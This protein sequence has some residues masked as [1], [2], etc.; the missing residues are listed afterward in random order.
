M[1]TMTKVDKG[2]ARSGQFLSQAE[3]QPSPVKLEAEIAL[4]WGYC[5]FVVVVRNHHVFAQIL[6]QPSLSLLTAKPDQTIFCQTLLQ[7]ILS[8]L[9]V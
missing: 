1:M 7:P 8:L 5:L 9:I 4:N 6:L 3:P 2:L